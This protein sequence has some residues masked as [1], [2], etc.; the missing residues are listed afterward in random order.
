[1]AR[2]GE[3]LAVGKCQPGTILCTTNQPAARAM[4]M[5]IMDA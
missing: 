4:A 2:R 5:E 1:M 3:V